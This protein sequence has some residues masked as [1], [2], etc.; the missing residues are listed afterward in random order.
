MKTPDIASRNPATGALLREFPEISPAELETKIAAA[1]LAYRGTLAR[2]APEVVAARRRVLVRAAEILER[3]A[4]E[5]AHEITVEMGKTFASSKAEVL[6]SAKGCRYY[7]D[8]GPAMLLPEPARLDSG[9]HAEI[10]YEPL[11]IVLAIMPWNFP[12]WQV[13][14]CA[15]PILLS[16][17][18]LVLK[19]ASNVPASALAIESIWHEAL[20]AEK[21]SK[22]AFST[23]LLSS[24]RVDSLISDSRIRGVTLTGSEGAGRKVAASAGSSL[25]KTVLEL[26]GSDPFIVLPTA[27]LDRA[28]GVAVESRMLANG[29]SCI[30]AKRFLVHR[31]LYPRFRENFVAKMSSLRMGDPLL[32]ETQ[33]GPLATPRIREDLHALVEDAR[34]KGAKVLCGGAIPDGPGN[35]YPPTVLDSVDTTAK[36]YREEAFGPLAALYPFDTLD[37]AIEIANATDFGLGASLWTQDRKEIEICSRRIESGQLF[38]NELVASDPAVPFGGVK[39]S[40]YGRELGAF[41]VREWTVARTLVIRKSE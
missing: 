7:A 26:G 2:P 36:L 21:E 3:R 14:R 13:F 25:K 5:F 28:I 4:D 30:A 24:S 38:V 16:G 37:E 22:G 8:H 18:S 1:D 41:G 31:S 40:G 17:N 23:L 33:V 12:F 11:G 29:Q 35:F 10:R 20:E 9:S 6:K 27:N 32:A 34:A 19:H 15:A 39:N